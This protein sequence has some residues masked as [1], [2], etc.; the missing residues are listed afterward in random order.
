ME[1]TKE[2]NLG[3]EWRKWDLQVQTILDDGYVS[4]DTYWDDLKIKFAENC[5]KLV[6]AIGSE[7][8]VKKYDSKSY[9]FTES[10][11]SPKSRADNYAK[12][13]LNF[14][15]IFNENVGAIC[16]TDHNYDHEHLL[17]ALVRKSKGFNTKVIPGVEVNNQGVHMLVLFSEIPY[18][19]DSFSAG[20]KTFL[21]KIN[22]DNKKTNGTLTVS[23]K[24]YSEVLKI[25][26]DIDAL[27]I[28]P[29]C[30]S[31]NGLFQERGKTDRTHLADQFNAQ[32]VNI[33]QAK[34]LSSAIATSE[35]IKSNTNFKSKHVFTLG[36]DARCLKNILIPDNAGNYCWIKADSTPE[37]LKQIVYEPETR[38][39][40]GEDKPKKPINKINS[41]LLQ[42]PEDAKVC[43][44]K[45]CFADNKRT[46]EL[47]PYF[48]CF[49]G[50][51]GSGK[52]TILNFLGLHSNNPESP[53]NFWKELTPSFNPSDE[54]IFSFQGTEL[55]EF[56][57]QSEIES[58]AKDKIKF[59]K[60]IY[61]RANGPN[62]VLL[63]FED[64]I[65]A[66]QNELD[67]IIMAVIDTQGFLI[68]K[69]VKEKEKRSLES[70]RDI[71]ESENYREITKKISE[72]SQKLQI[73]KKWSEE[74]F[75]LRVHLEETIDFYS[76]FLTENE[77]DIL[78]KNF[79]LLAVEKVKEAINILKDDNFEA[80]KSEE[81]SHLAELLILEEEIKSLLDKGKYSEENVEQI[82]SAPQKIIALEQEIE[83]LAF[84]SEARKKIIMKYG[85]INEN[86]VVSKRMYED[87]LV[88]I[89]EPLLTQLKEQSEDNQDEDI[90]N[91]S[92]DYFFNEESA[93]INLAIEFYNRFKGSYHDR[94]KGAD[95]C[96]F[97]QKNSTEFKTDNL[98]NLRKFILG[99]DR[100]LKYIQFLEGVF[101][102]P[103]NFQI[104]Q[105]IRDKHLYDVKKYKIIQVEYDGK[106]VEQASFGQRCTAVVVVLILFGNYPL[107]IDEPEAHLDS[108]LI[109]NYLVPLL[110]K[111]KSDR[112]I[113]FA[114]HN[115]NFLINGDSEKIFVLKNDSGTTEIIETTIEDI[116]HRDELLKLEGGKE[117]F[118]KRGEK[119]HII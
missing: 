94:E 88:E 87:S 76:N 64:E 119:L 17:D 2:V 92:L 48:N 14:I 63:K 68:Q 77:D 10:A 61:D 95:V 109:A 26:K 108:S 82:K 86:L 97:I 116:E 41:F 78:Y 21:S 6:A 11:D 83:Q 51:R 60:A 98:E 7:E 75:L 66:F 71:I 15:D 45:F 34:N 106:P 79:Y 24:S 9:F 16:V 52:S 23:D 46:Y 28:Y 36:S 117:A 42:I 93:W 65:A 105:A 100:E 50:G 19:Q 99:K 74:V 39:S 5:D 90:K 115:A 103:L 33:L 67:I 49:I 4:I 13:L 29:H 101:L 104:F 37:G 8:L 85:A 73:H 84:L 32:S 112:Q 70:T 72:L 43:N 59:T 12:L 1:T 35:Y 47:S 56:L 18:G 81:Q 20:V 89:V 3:S 38:V 53:R 40:I 25:A 31:D 62:K 102:D 44:E 118:E 107:I 69:S 114:T 91:I 110:K 54:N 96:D 22:I 27:L 58:F 57:A 113:I 55:F 111:K 80:V 30:N